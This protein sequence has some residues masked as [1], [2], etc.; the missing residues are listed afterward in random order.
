MGRGSKIE[1]EDLEVKT[2]MYKI[3]KGVR[4]KMPVWED[5]EFES[6]HN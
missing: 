3:N 4:V 2:T 5:A 6:P 1:V